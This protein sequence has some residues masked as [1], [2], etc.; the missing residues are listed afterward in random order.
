MIPLLYILIQFD[1]IKTYAI[2]YKRNN[3]FDITQND[4]AKLCLRFA[5]RT[6]HFRH[7]L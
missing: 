1:T 5:Q 3:K 4:G 7:Q 6:T 2:N